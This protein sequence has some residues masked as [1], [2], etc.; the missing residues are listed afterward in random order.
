MAS[1]SRQVLAGGVIM[2]ELLLE[3]AVFCRRQMMSRKRGLD[4]LPPTCS[5]NFSPE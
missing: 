3:A 2:L 1:H 5:F 4:F